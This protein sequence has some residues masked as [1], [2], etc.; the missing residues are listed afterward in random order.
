[1]FRKQAHIQLEFVL[2]LW[3]KLDLYAL[4]DLSKII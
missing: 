1:M 3:Q 2:L 4:N